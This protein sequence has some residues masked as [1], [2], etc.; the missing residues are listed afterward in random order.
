MSLQSQIAGRSLAYGQRIAQAHAIG[1]MNSLVRITRGGGW[2][3]TTYEYDPEAEVVIYDH[4]DLPGSGNIAG[5]ATQS[6][7]QQSDYA[8]EPTYTSTTQVFIP[9][10]APQT[11]R[12]DDLVEILVCPDP[13]AEGEVMRVVDVTLGGRMSSSIQLTVTV[14]PASKEAT[15]A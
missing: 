3:P 10:S 1:S 15:P 4:P 11:P 7:S 14:S 6:G 13:E 5:V 8:D 2:D 12:I 9:Q